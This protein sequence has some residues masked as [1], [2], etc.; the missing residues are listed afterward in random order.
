MFLLPHGGFLR[1]KNEIVPFLDNVCSEAPENRNRRNREK[2]RTN[3]GAHSRSL[4][5][6]VTEL[7]IDI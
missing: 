2:I 1:H 5:R 7:G 6:Q 3:E 4:S